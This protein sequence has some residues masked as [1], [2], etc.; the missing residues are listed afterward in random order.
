MIFK[1]LMLAG[2]GYVVG[3]VVDDLLLDSGVAPKY[4]AVGGAIAGALI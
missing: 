2:L 4:A 3:Q 1:I